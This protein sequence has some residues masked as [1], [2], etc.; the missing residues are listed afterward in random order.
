MASRRDGKTIEW[1]TGC[2]VGQD[3]R[4]TLFAMDPVIAP[5]HD[6][7]DGGEECSSFLGKPIFAVPVIGGDIFTPQQAVLSQMGQPCRKNGLRDAEPLL[8]LRKTADSEKCVA[9]DHE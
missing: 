3:K 5:L 6:R 1:F 8:E 2:A 4:R 7:H 9:E